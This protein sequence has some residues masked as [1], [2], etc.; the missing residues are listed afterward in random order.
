MQ[1][2]YLFIILLILQVHSSTFG[3]PATTQNSYIDPNSILSAYQRFLGAGSTS[4]P[5]GSRVAAAVR[6]AGLPSSQGVCLNHF[7]THTNAETTLGIAQLASVQPNF[8]GGICSK[9]MINSATGFEILLS[10]PNI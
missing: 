3:I 2:L 9:S 7:F 4:G 10:P 1:R 5:G 6:G 8:V